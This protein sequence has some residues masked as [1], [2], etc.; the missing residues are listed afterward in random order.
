MSKI[1]FSNIFGVIAQ[2]IITIFN[3]QIRHADLFSFNFEC[4][5]G[6]YISG[7]IRSRRRLKFRSVHHFYIFRWNCSMDWPRSLFVPRR[8][9]WAFLCR[10]GFTVANARPSAS[11]LSPIYTRHSSAH[12]Q[13]NHLWSLTCLLPE[14]FRGHWERQHEAQKPSSE[15][16]W[17]RSHFFDTPA[18][19]LERLVLEL[20]R[21]SL[22]QLL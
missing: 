19:R 9:L 13:E 8:P 17:K 6:E 7:R 3:S 2:S 4:H 14:L 10:E 11:V 15:N 1:L 12:S 20:T 22:C 16:E 5:I 18:R 21:V